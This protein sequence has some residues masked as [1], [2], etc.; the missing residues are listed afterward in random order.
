MCIYILKASNAHFLQ[1][2]ECLKHFWQQ[3]GGNG[4]KYNKKKITTRPNNK[5]QLII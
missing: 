2:I 4:G 5:N 1:K 3:N